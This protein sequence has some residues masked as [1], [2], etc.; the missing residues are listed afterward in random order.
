MVHK[1]KVVL[2]FKDAAAIN[3]RVFEELDKQL[4]QLAGGELWVPAGFINSLTQLTQNLAFLF[5]N[6]IVEI[7]EPEDDESV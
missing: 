7:Q 6:G 3:D 5:E 4:H 2:S 1:D